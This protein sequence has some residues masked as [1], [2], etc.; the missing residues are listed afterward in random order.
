[1]L[2]NLRVSFGWQANAKVVHRS[3]GAKVDYPSPATS[4]RRSLAP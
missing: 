1:M 2:A 4:V 3:A